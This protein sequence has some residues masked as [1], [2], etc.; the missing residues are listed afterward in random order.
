MIYLWGEFLEEENLNLNHI[1]KIALNLESKKNTLRTY[2]LEKI[3]NVLSKAGS[4]WQREDFWGV[5]EVLTTLPTLLGFSKE[6]IKA[7]LKTLS[8]MLEEKSLRE[9]IGVAVD[10]KEDVCSPRFLIDRGYYLTYYPRGCVV[11]IT[12]GNVFI[13][14]VDSLIQGLISK[15]V[16]ILKTS[17]SN[18][19]FPLLFAKSLKEVDKDRV[20]SNSFCIVNFP[21]SSIEMI[22]KLVKMA[23]TLIVWGGEEA[24]KT[25][26]SL[27]EREKPL[28]TFGPR[29]SFALITEGA[30]KFY[31]AKEL[32][33][34]L[35]LDVV[36]WEQ[37]A[38]SSPQV[39]YLPDSQRGK[40]F[41]FYLQ[42]AFSNIE[43]LL[44]QG[45]LTVDEKIEITRFRQETRVEEALGEAKLWNAPDTSW[46][47][48]YYSTP[49]FKISPLNRCLTVCGFRDIKEVVN[50][51]LPVQEY[52]QSMGL[53]ATPDEISYISSLFYLIG[54]TRITPIGS[55]HKGRISSP[56]EG[57][58]LV[59]EL[60]KP[61]SFEG[62]TFPLSIEK[63]WEKFKL[64]VEFARDKSEYYSK[65]L[66]FIPQEPSQIPKLPLLTKDTVAKHAPPYGDSLLTTTSI[67]GGYIFATGGTTRK[68]RFIYYSKD[69]FNLATDILAEIFLKAG[70]KTSDRVAN[71]FMAGNLWSSF[72]ASTQAVEKIGALS[73]P[74][75]GRVPQEQ[76]IKFLQALKPT[77]LIGIPSLILALA[78]QLVIKGIKLPIRLVLYGGEAISAG[79]ESYLKQY[80]GA[81]RVVSAGYALVET[82]PVGYACR[83]SL[84]G[85]HHIL[86]SY[87][88]VEVIDELCNPVNP[89]EDGELV[90]TPLYK[91]VMPLIR[92]RSGDR[93]RILLGNCPCGDPS[94][95]VQLLGRMEEQI[96]VGTADISLIE[97]EE[98][99]NAS[100]VEQFQLWVEE[101]SGRISLRVKIKGGRPQNIRELMLANNS[102]LKEAVEE[103]WIEEFK[104]EETVSDEFIRHPRT[105]KVLKVVNV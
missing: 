21:A 10:G 78:E 84:Q 100:G 86:T 87:Q 31:P 44:P 92:L 2:P 85:V 91:K 14:A 54:V 73:L 71:L 90:I 15:N 98:L 97:L 26:T 55:M 3:I 24:I 64:L 48:S 99:L 27:I 13:G 62:D 19:I 18:P 83:A 101:R 11:H 81:E 30:L 102:E 56:H 17:H 72:L 43:G 49:K 88:W 76:L 38:C 67:E 53:G 77:I 93:G 33:K 95:R 45:E 69:E 68:P 29:W 35:A 5:K 20:V 61:V 82:G 74:L 57:R 103:R 32:A 34:H 16:N 89:G 37:R 63:S 52:L 65:T 51:L 1:K 7:G 36:M 6:M 28:L 42:E 59:R 58:W 23:D 9:L 47:L 40:E 60:L 12:A 8:E 79:G 96:R 75:G 39:L 94:P 50:C 66:S 105:G 80:L 41:L 70:I 104:V 25:Y 22:E 46:T 4:L